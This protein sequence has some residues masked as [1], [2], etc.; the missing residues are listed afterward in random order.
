[1]RSVWEMSVGSGGFSCDAASGSQ[2]RH[3]EAGRRASAE[4]ILL[5]CDCLREWKKIRHGQI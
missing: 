2:N 3:N 1:M 5:I 4:R